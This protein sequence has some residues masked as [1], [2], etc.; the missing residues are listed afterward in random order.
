MAYE[1]HIFVK[2]QFGMANIEHDDIMV[3]ANSSEKARQR[4]FAMPNLCNTNHSDCIFNSR[5]K[6]DNFS[7]LFLIW[8]SKVVDK[9]FQTLP[10][11]Q[12][13]F[14]DFGINNQKILMF[15][16]CRVYI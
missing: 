2:Q 10:Q 11:V 15:S 3:G 7:H 1:T 4:T 9:L 6:C 12:A 14:P 8:L 5:D 13:F 16:D